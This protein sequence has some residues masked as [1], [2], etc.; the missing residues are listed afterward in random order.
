MNAVTRREIQMIVFLGLLALAAV[1]MFPIIVLV[2]QG[3]RG[4]AGWNRIR[5]RQRQ[6][7]LNPPPEQ[8]IDPNF[9]FD[10]PPRRSAADE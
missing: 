7:R 9:M 6:R 1:L 8:P 3:R 5:E 4:H 10:E 2:A